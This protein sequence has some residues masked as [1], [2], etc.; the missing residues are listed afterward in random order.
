LNESSYRYPKIS[1]IVPSYNRAEAIKLTLKHLARQSIS[2]ELFE[3]L[4]V[5]DGSQDNTKEIVAAIENDLSIEYIKQKN[6]GVA[7]TRNHGAQRA[8]ANLLLFLDADVIPESNLL[9][10]HIKSHYSKPEKLVVGR[11]RPWPGFPRRWYDQVVDPETAGM[12]YGDKPKIVPFYMSLGGNLSLTRDAFNQIGGYDESFPEAGVEETEF[13]YRAEKIGYCLSYQPAAIGY[14]NHPR[15][16]PERCQQQI[17]HM[18]SM[19][20]L[21]NKHPEVQT[22]IYGVDELMPIV[23]EPK[24]VKNMVKRA[25][26]AFLGTRIVRFTLY[27]ALLAL[28]Q[29]R[30][31]PRITSFLYWRLY[32][33]SCFVGF[34]EGLRLY[35]K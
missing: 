15:T 19:A 12:D 26:A 13:A 8:R 16:L 34:R 11:V 32:T 35:A 27:R 5:D 33:G 22:R 2:A 3:V 20:L 9:E 7:A 24:R 17:A 18:R 21:L 10:T 28:D 29:R 31:W 1:V 6:R 25:H 23:A 4:V 14:H 30:M